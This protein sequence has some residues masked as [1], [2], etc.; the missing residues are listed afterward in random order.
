M[1]TMRC[2]LSVMFLAV[3]VVSCVGT[4]CRRDQSN[5]A[6]ADVAT[7]PS[8]MS[9]ATSSAAPADTSPL[10]QPRPVGPLVD[11]EALTFDTDDG[12]TIRG[13]KWSAGSPTSPV[14][15][16][17]HRRLGTR[18]EWDPLVRRLLPAKHPMHLIAF[19]SRGHGESSS[20]KKTNR[21]P[22]P[23]PGSKLKAP[24][25]VLFDLEALHTL[26]TRRPEQSP[27]AWIFVGS[28]YGANVVVS[29]ANKHPAS[30][31]GLG[32]VS[33]GQS[34]YGVELYQPFGA[35]LSL[36]NL[37]LGS[38]QD[39]I[40]RE[41]LRTLAAMSRSS[42]VIAYDQPGHGA[43]YLGASTWEMWDDLADWIEQRVAASTTA[44]EDGG[45]AV[46]ASVTTSSAES[47]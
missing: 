16:L 3:A 18:H 44:V 6:H 15:V 9:S 11:G 25:D 23:A 41:P 47:P 19:D 40:A 13:T 29:Y 36:S 4:G 24:K 27:S 45:V 26:L 5:N 32:L 22:T 43:Q 39:T 14:V 46:E 31:V 28:S 2:S 7:T 12:V 10:R 1:R 21:N 17:V 38:Q 34:L 30:I 42:K 20:P 37:V 35:V 8:V 33:P